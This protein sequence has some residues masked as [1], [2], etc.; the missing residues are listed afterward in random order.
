MATTKKTN[1][2]TAID[3]LRAEVEAGKQELEGAELAQYIAD[4]DVLAGYLK[5]ARSLYRR[6]L[7]N[8]ASQKSRT[9]RKERIAKGLAL[10]AEAE[11]KEE[12]TV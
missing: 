1:T 2:E 8:L 4:L 3:A 6:E 11:A 9:A 12:A 10:L 7:A 5:E